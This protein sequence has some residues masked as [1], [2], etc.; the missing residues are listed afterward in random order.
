MIKFKKEN[1]DKRTDLEKEIDSLLAEMK[2]LC[3][4]SDEYEKVSK[5]LER[6]Y[7]LKDYD[8]DSNP[9]KKVD[10]NTLIAGFVNLVGIFAVLKHE[11]CR[12]VA[13]KALNFIHRIK[14]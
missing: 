2:H 10:P 1:K 8:K 9:R 13:S 7:A 5:E 11:E 14:I 3:P 12:I 4:T 6:L